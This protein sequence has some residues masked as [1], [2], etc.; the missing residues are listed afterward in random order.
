MLKAKACEDEVSTPPPSRF[1]SL[2][3]T[4]THHIA[5]Y[6]YAHYLTQ[7]NEKA[8]NQPAEQ[9][10]D[11]FRVIDPLVRHTS[12]NRSSSNDRYILVKTYNVS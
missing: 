3:H 4:H 11:I 6:L 10:L 7:G 8:S 5:D 1:H 9:V 2:T 12:C